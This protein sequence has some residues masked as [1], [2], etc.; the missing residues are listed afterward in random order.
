M[1]VNIPT[2]TVEMVLDDLLTFRKLKSK[3]PLAF[4]AGPYIEI[5]NEPSED[6]DFPAKK[7][8][9]HLYHK[10]T[11]V[12]W[13]M[14]LGEY[15]R[16]RENSEIKFGKHCNTLIAERDHIKNER[17]HAVIML[18]SSP[19][20]FLELGSFCSDDEICSK[21]LIVIDERY[22]CTT[23]FLSTGPLIEAARRGTTIE[24]IKY[25]DIEYCE[26][27]VADFVT[28]K[29]EMYRINMEVY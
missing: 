27:T 14:S 4:L 20:S 9:F 16:L 12:G 10:F 24:Y 6:E 29:W 18:P 17:V 8:R 26:K 28:D 21:M 5:E 3:S 13:D 2:K 23:S 22:K 1:S 11:K 7:L 15:Q 25:T 19:G